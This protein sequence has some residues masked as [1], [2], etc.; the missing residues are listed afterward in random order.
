[1]KTNVIIEYRCAKR[2]DPGACLQMQS[3]LANMQE[4]GKTN[5]SISSLSEPKESRVMILPVFRFQ[6]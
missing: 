6:G 5:R 2:G 4:I 1:M 3:R